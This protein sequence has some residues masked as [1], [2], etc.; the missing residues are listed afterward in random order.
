M[1]VRT[2]DGFGPRFARF[3]Q[4]GISLGETSGDVIATR[5]LTTVQRSYASDY[6]G[7]TIIL[8]AYMMVCL[9]FQL[10]GW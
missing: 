4:V 10:R 5:G 8:V 6:V 9:L 2:G 1:Q 7:L 3:W